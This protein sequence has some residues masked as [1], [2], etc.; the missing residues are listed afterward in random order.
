MT[1]AQISA[2]QVKQLRDATQAGMMDAK[3]ALVETGG[4]FDAAVTLLREKGIAKAG[5]LGDRETTEGRVGL[6]ADG[7]AAA[8]VLVGCNT[9]FV[10]KNDDFG[11]FVQQLA[12]HTLRSGAQDVDSLLASEWP[13]GGS[14][15]DARTETSS[16][17]GENVVVAK[18]ARFDAGGTGVLG[19]Y[20][21]GTGIGVIVDVQG[22]DTEDVRTF[23]Q[24]VAMHAAAA[25]PQYLSRDEVPAD[26]VEAEKSIYVKQLEGEGKPAEMLDKIATGKLNKWYSEIALVEQSWIFAKDRLGKDVSIGEYAKLTGQKAGGDVA[27]RG[28]ERFSVKG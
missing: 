21:H 2:S 20:L 3:K 26:A 19:T 14:V 22:P 18:V 6:A 10:A 16:S 9:D 11:S 24:D 15:E 13:Q 1:T 27:V 23:A 12:D 5:K 4:D 17:T 28:F 8:L 25:S 7:N